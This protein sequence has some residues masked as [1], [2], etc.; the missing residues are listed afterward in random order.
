M[1]AVTVILQIHGDETYDDLIAGLSGLM[2][3]LKA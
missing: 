1:P 2:K 3:K